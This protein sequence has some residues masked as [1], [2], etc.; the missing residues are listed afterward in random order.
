MCTRGQWTST[1]KTNKKF[2]LKFEYFCNLC[3]LART[4]EQNM[5]NKENTKIKALLFVNLH[6]SF[7]KTNW[8]KSERN[9]FDLD[10]FWI[11]KK[12]EIKIQLEAPLYYIF[13]LY[14]AY[15][16][17]K[18]CLKNNKNAFMFQTKSLILFILFCYVE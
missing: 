18:V 12:N 4:L 11:Q 14:S 7:L 9:W 2:C 13:F 17:T 15:K 6:R 16:N 10:W 8:I 5:Q 1:F 3:L